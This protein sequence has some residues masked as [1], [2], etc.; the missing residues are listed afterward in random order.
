M[1]TQ[2]YPHL[3]IGI[4]TR[5]GDPDWVT[6][7]T[8]NYLNILAEY[9]VT[10]V[11][12]SPDLPTILPNGVR[13]APDAAGRLS[14]T[15]LEHL[16]GVVFSGGGDVDPK[17][18]G[19]PLNGAEPESI[20]HRRDELEIHLGQAA[21]AD[22]LPVFAI[23][24][25]CQVLNV[26]A[27]GKMVQHFDNHRSAPDGT[28]YH[29]VDFV[30]QSRVGQIVGQ[31]ALVVNTFHHQGI[32][33]ATLAPIFAPAAIAT[34]DPWLIEAYESPSHRWVVGVQW[35]PERIFELE[36][37][38]RRLWESFLAACAERKPARNA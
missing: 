26:A 14:A 2:H 4:T 31:P 9:H 15:V 17:Y 20:D 16:D 12:L 1:P 36:E 25:G 7:S 3:V 11:I 28:R 23:C 19:E 6:K 5:R 32:D 24:R 18:F 21:L 37:G 34:P 27:G 38:H 8:K 22:D 33:R 29:P 30:P 35:H 10:S 13:F